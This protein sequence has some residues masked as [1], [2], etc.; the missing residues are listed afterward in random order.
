MPSIP[1]LPRP[2]RIILRALVYAV[3]I[4]L[5]VIFMPSGDHVFVYQE[6]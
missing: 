6:F 4:A 3:V 2:A 5:I 1:D